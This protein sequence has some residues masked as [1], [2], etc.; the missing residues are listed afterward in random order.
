MSMRII[1][2][3][4]DMKQISEAGVSG[5][6]CYFTDPQMSPWSRRHVFLSLKCM[7]FIFWRQL[8]KIFNLLS[9]TT[10]TQM[11][12]STVA[13]I[14]FS[15]IVRTAVL[16]N[17]HSNRGLWCQHETSC[18]IQGV[19]IRP[20]L[21]RGPFRI[22]WY[23]RL[24]LTYALVYDSRVFHFDSPKSFYNL[25]ARDGRQTEEHNEIAER[26]RPLFSPMLTCLLFLCWVS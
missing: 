18:A 3:A 9:K 17:T 19:R 15:Q 6:L 13:P 2:A 21:K 22:S 4:I 24:W 20:D 25:Y 26:V 14:S 7:P 10:I 23:A 1:D 11:N 8:M 12:H 5:S 16:A